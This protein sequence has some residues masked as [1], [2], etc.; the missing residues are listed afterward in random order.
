MHN[1][2]FV[3]VCDNA[4]VSK[5]NHGDTLGTSSE[6]L[7]RCLGCF[8]IMH[9]VVLNNCSGFDTSLGMVLVPVSN[10]NPL[11]GSEND[12]TRANTKK[13]RTVRA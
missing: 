4:S 5:T 8:H 10:L 6:E 12:P 11:L 2:T 9:G 3:V 13:A 1:S 7:H